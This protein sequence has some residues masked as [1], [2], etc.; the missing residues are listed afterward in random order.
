MI[1]KVKDIALIVK[2]S[3]STIFFFLP[4]VINLKVCIISGSMMDFSTM[5]IDD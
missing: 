2:A 1:V 4:F 5:L 3:L